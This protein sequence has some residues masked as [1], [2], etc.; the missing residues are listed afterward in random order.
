MRLSLEWLLSC[1]LLFMESKKIKWIM[2]LCGRFNVLI[3]KMV[4]ILT[5][6]T[7]SDLS[8]IPQENM[9]ALMEVVSTH[10]EIAG[11]DVKLLD[12]SN[13]MPSKMDTIQMILSSKSKEDWFLINQKMKVFNN[14]IKI[15]F[16][17]KNCVLKIFFSIIFY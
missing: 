6:V 3:K 16:I 1:Y 14:D 8:M 5:L 17:Y 7:K 2:V 4:N 10:K 13:F 9:S 11:V 12:S 15:L